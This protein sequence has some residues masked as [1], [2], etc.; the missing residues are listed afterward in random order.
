MMSSL[1]LGMVLLV[2]TCWLLFTLPSWLGSTDFGTC[3]FRCS[4]SI[5]PQFPCVC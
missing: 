1:L 4:L 2:C 5:L 3:S